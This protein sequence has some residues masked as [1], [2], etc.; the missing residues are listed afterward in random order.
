MLDRTAKR[1]GRLLLAIAGVTSIA[2]PVLFAAASPP[3][4]PAQPQSVARPEFE[5][6]SVQPVDPGKPDAHA[7]EPYPGG[8]RMRSL[9]V[10]G[11]LMWAYQIKVA[12]QI[13]G[14]PD[15]VHTQ[16]FDITAKAAEPVSTHQLRL[17][18]QSLLA[19]RFKLVLHREQRIVPLYSLVVDKSGPKLHEVQQE[20][21]SGGMLGWTDGMVTYKMVNHI[22]ELAAMLP[23]FLEGRPV[24]DETG[25]TGVYELTLNVEVDPDQ[26]KRMPQ[27][28]M[29]F[30]GFGYTSGIFNAV[31]NLGLKLEAAK[32]PMDFFVID[33]LEHPSGN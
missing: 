26:M 9:N 14:G 5:V 27:A 3:P 7:I 6:A 28:G 25:L 30:T 33:R 1:P 24:Q 4:V 8:L 17:M 29:A 31:K 13:S 2:G 12:N 19:E 18:L 11:L 32:G 16:D 22:A 20:P 21:K 23:T 10:I 15:W